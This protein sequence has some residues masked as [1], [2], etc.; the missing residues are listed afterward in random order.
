MWSVTNLITATL[1]YIYPTTVFAEVYL[2]SLETAD[3]S[4]TH[5]DNKWIAD[6]SGIWHSV[7]VE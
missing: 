2:F 1:V 4:H 5:T 7:D 3:F 6:V